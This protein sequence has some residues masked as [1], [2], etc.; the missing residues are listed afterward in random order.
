MQHLRRQTL[1][2][3]TLVLSALATACAADEPAEPTEPGNEDTSR[4]EANMVASEMVWASKEL[5][6]LVDVPLRQQQLSTWLYSTRTEHSVRTCALEH[7][8]SDA[9]TRIVPTT[10]YAV[11]FA[12]KAVG[13]LE[14]VRLEGIRTDHSTSPE[15]VTVTC[16]R[17][18]GLPMTFGDVQALLLNRVEVRNR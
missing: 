13:G 3:A 15:H 1:V 8:S 12:S 11:A 9:P 2:A 7:E 16:T 4:L 6:F 18:D 17:S 5:T 14:G 10:T